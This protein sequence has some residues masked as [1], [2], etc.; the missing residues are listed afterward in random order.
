MLNT[1]ISRYLRL[2]DTSIVSTHYDTTVV[3]TRYFEPFKEKKDDGRRS[4]CLNFHVSDGKFGIT[5]V[6]RRVLIY[7]AVDPR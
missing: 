4:F 7:R 5:G 2:L 6:R 3:L 1:Q